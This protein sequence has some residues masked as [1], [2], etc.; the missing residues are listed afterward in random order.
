MT[1]QIILLSAAASKQEKWRIRRLEVVRRSITE[2]VALREACKLTH[3]RDE[4]R[5]LIAT[6]DSVPSPQLLS[7]VEA[8]WHAEGEDT[9]EHQLEGGQRLRLTVE[10]FRG[11]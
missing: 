4:G 2:S 3:L 10:V 6:Y 1:D 11:R 5:R 8:S 7:A 9:V